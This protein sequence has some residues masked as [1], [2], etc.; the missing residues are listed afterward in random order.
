MQ[1]QRNILLCVSGFSPAIITETLWCLTQGYNSEKSKFPINEIFIITT[2]DGKEKFDDKIINSGEFEQF[3]KDYSEYSH[4]KISYVYIVTNQLNK[5]PDV[6]DSKEIQLKD[7]K[8]DK[9]NECVAN[10][11]YMITKDLIEN[12]TRLHASVAGGRKT[13]GIYLSVMMQ[14]LARAEDTLSHVLVW[15][16]FEEDKDFTYPKPEFLKSDRILPIS[17]AFIPFIRL[18]EVGKN[19]INDLTISEDSYSRVVQKV[20]E[21]LKLAEIEDKLVLNLKEMTVSVG[22]NKTKISGTRMMIVLLYAL[23]QGNWL[24]NKEL[25]FKDFDEAFKKLNRKGFGYEQVKNN[26]SII[27]EGLITGECLDAFNSLDEI[28]KC[29]NSEKAD[30]LEEFYKKM[31]E[32]RTRINNDVLKGKANIPK[33]F[34]IFNNG[35]RG[36]AQYG[37][38]VKVEIIE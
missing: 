38:N 20:K 30:K 25:E 29:I 33:K 12:S 32:W 17:L 14:L 34:H 19:L 36:E 24:S 5:K 16:D 26:R 10:Q 3:K 35:K 15:D 18:R 1:K 27:G 6:L 13:M 31:R 21:N 11:I 4:V 22:E 2:K 7:V 8:T 23:N 37:F 9:E 28:S